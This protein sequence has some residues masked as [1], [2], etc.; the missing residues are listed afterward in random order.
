[1]FDGNKDNMEAFLDRLANA[2]RDDAAQ[3]TNEILQISYGVSRLTRDEFEQI[4]GS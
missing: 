2:L 4:H 3:F 1:M